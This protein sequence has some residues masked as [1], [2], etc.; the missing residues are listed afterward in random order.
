MKNFDYRT[1]TFYGCPF[2]VQFVYFSPLSLHVRRSYNPKSQW[3]LVWA[4]SLSLAATQEIAVAFFSSGYLDVSVP[5]VAP[6]H[7][8][9][10][11]EWYSFFER[12]GYPIRTSPDQRLLTAPRSISVFVPSFIGS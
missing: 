10:S 3:L 8:M 4:V 5:L 12:V 6:I 1:V 9:D 11:G 2:Q 7:P